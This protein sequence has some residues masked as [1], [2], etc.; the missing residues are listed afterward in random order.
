MRDLEWLQRELT[1]LTERLRAAHSRDPG[2][3]APSD[4]RAPLPPPRP[5]VQPERRAS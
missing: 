1:R 3:A 5:G 4:R 2:P